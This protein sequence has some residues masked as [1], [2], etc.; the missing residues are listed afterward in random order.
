MFRFRRLSL[1]F[2][3]ERGCTVFDESTSFSSD[4]SEGVLRKRC[5]RWSHGRSVRSTE[6][7]E[8]SAFHLAR[9]LLVSRARYRVFTFLFFSFFS[10]LKTW[11]LY[12]V[13]SRRRCCAVRCVLLHVRIF[14]RVYDACVRWSVVKWGLSSFVPLSA[15]INEGLLLCIKFNG[16][17]PTYS[18][19]PVIVQNNSWK[20]PPHPIAHCV[21]AHLA[22][23]KDSWRKKKWPRIFILLEPFV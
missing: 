10:V 4:W 20:T 19:W 1:Q 13:Q 7:G 22:K 16:V 8:E 14:S 21:S 9:C 6:T 18:V 2:L 15:L 11:E 12:H 3:R 23:F 5:G 17:R